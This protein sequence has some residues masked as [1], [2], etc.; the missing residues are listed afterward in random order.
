MKFSRQLYLLGSMLLSA[1]STSDSIEDVFSVK[2]NELDSSGKPLPAS[3]RSSHGFT[4][5]SADGSVFAG[6]TQYGTGSF[7]NTQPAISAGKTSKGADGYNLNLL[8]APINAAAKSVLG[9]T[10]GVNYVVDPRV[11]GKITLQT[12]APVS[13][14]VLLDIFESALTVNGAVITKQNGSYQIVP[15]SEAFS[16]T[17][18]I[19]TAVSSLGGP[20]I[21]VQALELKY[22]AAAEMK[23]ILEPISRK[24]SILRTDDRRNIIV[25]AG[26]SNDLSAMRNAIGIFDVDWMKGMSVALHPLKASQSSAVAKELGAIFSTENGPGSNIIRFIPNERLNA[27]LVITSRPA[28]LERAAAWISKLD[29]LAATNEERLF[30][31]NI[32]NRPAKELAQV[33]Q[34]V[35]KGREGQ[36]AAQ[37]SIENPIAPDLQPATISSAY[38]ASQSEVPANGEAALLSNPMG[39]PGKPRTSVVA[40]IENNALL[41][42]TTAREYERIEPLLR[43]L[44]VVPTQVMLEAVIAEVTLNDELRF[45]LRWFFENGNF[46]VGFSDLSSGGTG[47]SFPALAWSYAT[48]DIRVTL[49]ALSSITDVNVV[50]APTLMAL[51]N[52]KAILQIGDQVPIVTRQAQ[53]TDNSDAPVINSVEMKDT[54]IIL[55]VTPRINT[56]GKVMLDIQ[57]EVS[58][59]VKTTSSGIDSPTIQQRKVS[60][61]VVV[62]D[63]ESLALGGLIQQ[64][65]DL[66]RSQVP[67][68]GDIPLLGNAFKHKTDQIRK[69][70]LIIF[71]RPRIVRDVNEARSVTEEFRQQLDFSSDIKKRR[72]GSS[73]LEQDMKRLSY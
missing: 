24:G 55:T 53:S 43:Q 1:C 73:K 39:Q 3:H 27:V 20:G 21:K 62:N 65:N 31:Y 11:S 10:L 56:S 14:E 6:A 16:S 50:S 71:I 66:V 2:L 29:R 5:R 30:V 26:T 7:L 54:G 34:S 58:D 22:V 15:A 68:L 32:Q 69:T 45:G 70:E 17:P 51:N 59:V 36:A 46:R 47:A 33:L 61:R 41:I 9:D 37:G 57:Q 72:G 23:S 12:A 8:D 42:S 63:N 35:L 13:K 48:N 67:I 19:T 25:L 40:D 52:Q 4:T 49:N 28:Y 44:D 18:E 60:T 64:R 38:D